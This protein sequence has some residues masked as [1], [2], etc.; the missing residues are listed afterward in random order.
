MPFISTP[1]PLAASLS[2]PLSRSRRPLSNVRLA[3]CPLS[4][5]SINGEHA[6]LLANHPSSD[7]DA[8]GE[9]ELL[10]D[11]VDPG[12]ALVA[13]NLEASVGVEHHCAVHDE[14]GG[15]AA[16]VHD[17]LGEDGRVLAKREVLDGQLG[18]EGGLALLDLL[19]RLL[20]DNLLDVVLVGD[21]HVG[22][23]A[24]EPVHRLLGRLAGA[25]ARPV[26]VLDCLARAE[27]NGLHLPNQEERNH[28]EAP[29]EAEAQ[30]AHEIREG[31]AADDGQQRL[32]PHEALLHVLHVL[33]DHF[34]VHPSPPLLTT[35]CFTSWDAWR[36][37]DVRSRW[38]VVIGYCGG[39]RS[40]HRALV[41][42]RCF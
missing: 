15:N 19:G 16:V 26:E 2:P 7:A 27:L 24:V 1:P 30:R 17:E 13:G 4:S 28:E 40:D 32:A 33:L 12:G 20:V 21:P 39:E 10:D 34:R 14:L 23:G 5:S 8:R 25:Q 29:P 35:D 36:R 9:E 18:E 37:L 38:P 6:Y 41:Q 3:L 11:D 22:H 42:T 31:H